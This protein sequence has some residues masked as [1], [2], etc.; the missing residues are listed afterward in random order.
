[1][2]PQQ[3]FPRESQEAFRQPDG[4]MLL[5]RIARIA[6]QRDLSALIAGEL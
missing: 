6:A 3:E 2:I 5:L 4:S 1:L